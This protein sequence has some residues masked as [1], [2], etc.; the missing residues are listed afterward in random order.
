M[1]STNESAE[2][3]AVPTKFTTSTAASVIAPKDSTSFKEHAPNVWL[4]NPIVI[5]LKSVQLIPALETTSS[6]AISPNNVS[7]TLNT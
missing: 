7:A 1:T 2:F 3:S 4:D 5:I 6:T